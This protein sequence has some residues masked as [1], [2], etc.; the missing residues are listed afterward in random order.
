MI[1]KR[2]IVTKLTEKMIGIGETFIKMSNIV[3]NT[4]KIE[5]TMKRI[6]GLDKIM[7][8]CFVLRI[9]SNIET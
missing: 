6:G 5:E 2:T 8:K 9:Y 4:T 1:A 7:I 3:G